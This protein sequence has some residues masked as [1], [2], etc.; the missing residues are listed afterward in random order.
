MD[1]Q[2]L[3]LRPYWG[4]EP[5]PIHYSALSYSARSLS[6]AAI[7]VMRGKPNRF[8]RPELGYRS[9]NASRIELHIDSG[10]TLD[11]EL[12]APEGDTSLRITAGDTALFLRR[13]PG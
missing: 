5:A 4:Q 8:V 7:S 3:G 12:Y 9:C 11:G 6:R 2:F 13:A 10:F 1:R